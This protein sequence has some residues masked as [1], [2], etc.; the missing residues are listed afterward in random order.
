MK[1]PAAVCAALFVLVGAVAAEDRWTEFRGPATDDF[2]TDDGDQKK[3]YATPGSAVALEP[4]P[5]S[6]EL[7]RSYRS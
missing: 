7:G 2:G 5:E 3:G 1:R 6:R 4:G